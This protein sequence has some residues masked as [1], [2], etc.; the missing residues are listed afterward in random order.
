MDFRELRYVLSVASH[1][2]LTRAAQELY[3]S[4]PSLS[5]YLQNLERTTGMRLFDR[6]GNRLR[7]TYAGERYVR[8]ARQMLLMKRDMDEELGEIAR[9]ERGRIRVAIPILRSSYQMPR[10]LVAFAAAYPGVEVELLEQPSAVLERMLLSGEADVAL[11]NRPEADEALECEVLAQEEIVLVAEA[12]PLPEKKAS[13]DDAARREL[14][15]FAQARFILNHEDQRTGQI[16]RMLLR[17]AGIEP[18]ILLSTRS[19]EGAAAMAAQGLGL[20]F[21]PDTHLKHMHLT[22]QPRCIR[23][24]DPAARSEFVAA[25]RKGAFRPGYLRAFIEAVRNAMQ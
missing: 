18:R 4:Q 2:N 22:P 15:D 19:V 1:Q 24:S 20:A 11:M 5:K 8:Y 23:L 16:G 7:L 3:I 9:E 10:A 17:R 25:F 13:S 6:Q 14:A 12:E 21:T